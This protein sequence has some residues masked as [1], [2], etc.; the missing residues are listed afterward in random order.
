MK[1]RSITNSPWGKEK[2]RLGGAWN[3][4]RSRQSMLG[5]QMGHVRAAFGLKISGKASA[6]FFSSCPLF[7]YLWKA[8]PALC[9]KTTW[10]WSQN[11]LDMSLERQCESR[12]ESNWICFPESSTS[13][14]S[15]AMTRNQMFRNFLKRREQIGDQTASL[16]IH[17]SF[18]RSC[19]FQKSPNLH[20]FSFGFLR[21]TLHITLFS[22]F[23]I[24]WSSQ[25]SFVEAIFEFKLIFFRS[26]TI[27]TANLSFLFLFVFSH[28][29]NSSHHV[30]SGK[31]LHLICSLSLDKTILKSQ[32][33]TEKS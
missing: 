11:Q 19:D 8:I 23:R 14:I 1:S 16:S 31:L 21:L 5:S 10:L 7:F 2:T 4:L 6:P 24:S 22:K 25:I 27:Q 9:Q 26:V 15:K 28:W 3:L 17:Q 12:A 33:K 29:L 13:L 20:L 30:M 18:W 32:T